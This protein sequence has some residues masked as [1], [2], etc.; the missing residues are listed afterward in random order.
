MQEVFPPNA[1]IHITLYGSSN[2][3]T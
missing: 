3:R 1:Q 2:L